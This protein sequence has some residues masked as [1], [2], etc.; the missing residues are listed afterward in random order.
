MSCIALTRTERRQG[1]CT[2]KSPETKHDVHARGS[3]DGMVRISEGGLNSQTERG[4]CRFLVHSF[5]F[6][7]GANGYTDRSPCQPTFS[8]VRLAIILAFFCLRPQTSVKFTERLSL[9][10]LPSTMSV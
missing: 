2:L 4:S 8:I 1:F 3:L 10:N 5:S 7:L 9:C 6:S